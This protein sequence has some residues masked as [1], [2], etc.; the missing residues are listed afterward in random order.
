MSHIMVDIETLGTS[1]NSVVL[2]I[3]AA[4]FSE[5]GVE[6]KF[7]EVI[8]AT[9]CTDW[10]LVIDART[11][12]WWLEQ[13]EEARNSLTQ[14][15]GKALDIVLKDFA[16][17]FNWKDAQVWANGI[18]F[19]FTILEEAYKAIGM[20][21]PWAYWSKMDYRTVKNLVPRDVYNA[22]KVEAPI[23]HNA[24]ADAMSQA[25]TL[26]EMLKWVNRNNVTTV[27]VTKAAN[28]TAKSK[29]AK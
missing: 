25:A 9:S 14:T 1:K 21:A 26:I 2:A 16:T 19:D 11:V 10:G 28:D 4:Q 8:D 3:G 12:M 18:D 7:Y 22:I 24:L 17:A 23:K 29:K 5:K 15:K 27:P 20:N 13:S 6:K